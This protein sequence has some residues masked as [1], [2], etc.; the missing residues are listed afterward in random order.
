ME[1]DNQII[2]D[3]HAMYNDWHAPVPMPVEQDSTQFVQECIQYAFN[4]EP[5]SREVFALPEEFV[6]VDDL[7]NQ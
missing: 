3:I 6:T 5:M 2:K 7:H 1:Y 4:G